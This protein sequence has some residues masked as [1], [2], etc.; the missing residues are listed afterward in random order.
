MRGR[1]TRAASMISL[2]F[3]IEDFVVKFAHAIDIVTYV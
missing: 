1:R 2:M 3:D